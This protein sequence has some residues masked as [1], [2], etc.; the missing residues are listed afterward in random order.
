MQ[1][2][3]GFKKIIF[4]E[5]KIWQ[6]SVLASFHVEAIVFSR[7]SVVKHDFPVLK[8]QCKPRFVEN[9]LHKPFFL[10]IA[11]YP[12]TLMPDSQSL[13]FPVKYCLA[14]LCTLEQC[15]FRGSCPP[16]S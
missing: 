6:Q 11:S 4:H 9:V 10:W 7:L 15:C 13:L 1:I 5:P 8:E 12:V 2:H 14:G 3:L 16:L